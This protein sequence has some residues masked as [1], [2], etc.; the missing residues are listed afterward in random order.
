LSSSS[1]FYFFH[2]FLLAA[3]TIIMAESENYIT[4]KKIQL[5]RAAVAATT[6]PLPP[7]PHRSPLRSKLLPARSIS[8]SGVVGFQWS[9]EVDQNQ[10]WW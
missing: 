4:S 8:N 10:W 5:I 3:I 9:L 6:S 7:L 2:S 1:S